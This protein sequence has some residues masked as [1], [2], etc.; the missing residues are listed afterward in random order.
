MKTAA[1][2]L[3]HF[4]KGIKPNRMKTV[5]DALSRNTRPYHQAKAE[6]ANLERLA[7]VR[8]LT[9]AE[10]RHQE[11]LLHRIIEWEGKAA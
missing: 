8:E 10:V 4:S 6:F 7:A 5:S 11:R 1:D 2:A 3:S 9:E